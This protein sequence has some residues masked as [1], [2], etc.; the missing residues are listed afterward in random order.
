MK[1]EITMESVFFAGFK[2]AWNRL[3]VLFD[4][5]TEDPGPYFINRAR[6]WQDY[7]KSLETD[8]K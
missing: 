1:R 7:V 2:E 6:A 5:K 4:L 3:F 8:A